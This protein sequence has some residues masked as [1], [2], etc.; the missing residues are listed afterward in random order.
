MISL[1]W[2]H[3][4]HLFLVRW[5][6]CLVTLSV[7]D[8][9]RHT[10]SKREACHRTERREV[11][12]NVSVQKH[13]WRWTLSCSAQWCAHGPWPTAE[14]TA[15]SLKVCPSP[16]LLF[17]IS[18]S[19]ETKPCAWAIFQRTHILSLLKKKNHS[20]H[21]EV[22]SFENTP[23]SLECVF[24]ICLLSEWLQFAFHH[25]KIHF[26]SMVLSRLTLSHSHACQVIARVSWEQQEVERKWEA[27][28]FPIS[29]SAFALGTT[30]GKRVS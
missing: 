18:L 29:R 13:L 15:P 25:S 22:L 19:W 17:P 28:C 23:K 7:E 1:Y 2:C 14:I 10:G 30:V 3:H 9:L 8:E 26:P 24:A 21:E 20:G 12:L 6:T 4:L 27:W 5:I 16:D 11:A